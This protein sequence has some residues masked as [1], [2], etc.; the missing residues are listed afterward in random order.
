MVISGVHEEEKQNYKN[1][2]PQQTKYNDNVTVR[3]LEKQRDFYEDYKRKW[4]SSYAGNID[5]Q[6]NQ[7]ENINA[8]DV[9]I[10]NDNLW[11]YNRYMRRKEAKANKTIWKQKIALINGGFDPYGFQLRNADTYA[12]DIMLGILKNQ[13]V[14][15]KKQAIYESVMQN[16]Q[17]TGIPVGELFEKYRDQIL[18]MGPSIAITLDSVSGV[19]QFSPESVESF[20]AY[21]RKAIVD[22][23][24][25]LSDAISDTINSLGN[26]SPKLLSKHAIPQKF[27]VLK[28]LRDKF[29]VIND[30]KTQP[31]LV[32]DELTQR[33]AELYN[34]QD[35]SGKFID[36]DNYELASR[37][38][39]ELDRDLA[40]SMDYYGVVY[41]RSAQ[42]PYLNDNQKEAAE[43]G[44]TL[45]LNTMLEQRKKQDRAKR[46]ITNA[47]WREQCSNLIQKDKPQV[48]EMSIVESNILKT[49]HVLDGRKGEIADEDTKKVFD[50]ISENI[51]HIAS[52]ISKIDQEM[53]N[54]G[55]VFELQKEELSARPEL[56]KRLSI[57]IEERKKEQ[58]DLLDRAAGCM[59]ALK[60]LALGEELTALGKQILLEQ[61]VHV[62]EENAVPEREVEV[63][64]NGI[65]KKVKKK[66]PNEIGFVL[67]G[68][69]TVQKNKKEGI[70]RNIIEHAGTLLTY[71]DIKAGL[72]ERCKNKNDQASVSV[73]K[74]LENESR[75]KTINAVACLKGKNL[76]EMESKDIVALANEYKTRDSVAEIFKENLVELSEQ[77]DVQY[78]EYKD[79][80]LRDMTER[81][82]NDLVKKTNELRRKFGAIAF[83][84][85]H[86]FQDKETIYSRATT[87]ISADD[88]NRLKVLEKEA[89][90]KFKIV[91]DKAEQYRYNWIIEK[92]KTGDTSQDMYSKEEAKA[93]KELQ[94]KTEFKNGQYKDNMSYEQRV[95]DFFEK[96]RE[97]RSVTW[98]AHIREYGN[99]RTEQKVLETIKGSNALKPAD[100]RMKQPVLKSMRQVFGM[101]EKEDEEIR[102][103]YEEDE[104][105]NLWD[106]ERQEIL[107]N[108]HE[109]H[110][111]E[112]HEV[113]LNEEEKA[114]RL[115][116]NKDRR[117]NIDRLQG[118]EVES[119]NK[120]YGSDVLTQNRLDNADPL[121]NAKAFLLECALAKSINSFAFDQ[122]LLN[123]QNTDQNMATALKSTYRK[124]A[125]NGFKLTFFDGRL[126]KRPQS[127][128]TAS[129]VIDK[130][131]KDFLWFVN[132]LNNLQSV[133]V[134]S[135]TKL[136]DAWSKRKDYLL[137][138]NEQVNI[139]VYTKVIAV[140]DGFIGGQ[141]MLKR[142]EKA[143]SIKQSIDEYEV[144]PGSISLLNK[145]A[146]GAAMKIEK[147][148]YDFDQHQQGDNRCWAASHT[149]V[150]NTFMKVHKDEL[151]AEKNKDDKLEI[152]PF[153]QDTFFNQENYKIHEN[154]KQKMNQNPQ[155]V[156]DM[157]VDY[158]NEA[159][160][161]KNFLTQD[162]MGN[163]YTVADT[164]ITKIPKTAERH[165]VF[166]KPRGGDI[167]LNQNQ[168]RKL[169]N[170]LMTKVFNEIRRTQAPIS[171][172]V[173]YH[174][175]T[176]VGVNA[177]TRTLEC[178][179][180]Q[181]EGQNLQKIDHISVDDLV[182][183]DKFEMILPE[184]LSDVNL[185]QL[186]D[187]FGLK[188]DLYNEDGSMNIDKNIEDMQNTSLDNPVNMMHINGIEF[189][190]P[191]EKQGTEFEKAFFNEQIYMPKDLNLP[192]KLREQN[193]K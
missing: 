166:T 99:Y 43:G 20:T 154:V 81:Q 163:P 118:D 34:K 185:A 155:M 104:Q 180:S 121:A 64:E 26:I 184:Y 6:I 42:N 32:Q 51:K 19:P 102:V 189:D 72:I 86:A 165:I 3:E 108:E 65:K 7:P 139:R 37:L 2:V 78:G 122:R 69:T 87:G 186:K 110:D 16:V 25:A 120:E 131:D 134:K 71:K 112:Q 48:V 128:G 105:F 192:K 46:R 85:K 159:I 70:Q 23:V 96:K 84:K 15:N 91:N 12:I 127:I 9:T 124:L 158:K 100:Q 142:N 74:L 90:M 59:N 50:G 54:S 178:F 29:K 135:I 94:K 21:L 181:Y 187:E 116:A 30:L 193:N 83:L 40:Y 47:Y 88:L 27:D 60:N 133:D 123:N 1:F 10:S 148:D 38:Y 141:A 113:V 56:K 188:Q 132:E 24:S 169:G 129:M 115:Q 62:E 44:G 52:A 140:L 89:T 95:V 168:K 164:V 173:G 167:N 146:F 149:Y 28:E 31:A 107:H 160:N 55:N 156:N 67:L 66:D 82:V 68:N 143:E 39:S 126:I 191:E 190:K 80:N 11:Y 14:E 58:L 176:I 145:N 53:A 138:N 172:L 161:I 175:Y 117:K 33:F 93:L 109:N 49:V 150:I 136:R 171:I 130:N 119:F 101:A 98:A 75:A 151:D 177:D 111:E 17:N 22:P 4:S 174:Y 92:I 106:N 157:L 182:T 63:L 57:Y 76:L 103:N 179:N 162:R 147:N 35:E 18:T 73:R 125:A 152:Q 153:T 79:K 97:A 8:D 41:N 144:V 137:D 36:K 5:Y 183:R 77:I 45:A 13:Y 114:L 61:T 170:F